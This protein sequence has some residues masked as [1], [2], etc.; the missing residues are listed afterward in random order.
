MEKGKLGVLRT[1]TRVPEPDL[2]TPTRV[3][4]QGQILMSPINSANARWLPTEGRAPC[5]GE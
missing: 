5:W 2:S 3:L 1:P 4:F